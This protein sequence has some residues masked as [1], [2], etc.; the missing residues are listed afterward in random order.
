MLY[1]VCIGLMC[2]C[3]L[4]ACC[5]CFVSVRACFVAFR[6]VLVCVVVMLCGGFCCGVM[7]NVCGVLLCCVV[8]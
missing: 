5:L 2:V 7:C 3:A 4:F 6:F 8:V 1:V